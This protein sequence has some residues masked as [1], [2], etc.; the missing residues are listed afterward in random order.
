MLSSFLFNLL[1]VLQVLDK[2][3]REEIEIVIKAIRTVKEILKLALLADEIIL[4]I[5]YPK[6]S[7]PKI[8]SDLIN[9]FSKVA[10]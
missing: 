3:I 5:E 7:L 6:D 10:G 8:L 1:I 4:F 2:G 9:K